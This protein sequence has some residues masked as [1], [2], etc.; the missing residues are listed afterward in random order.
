VV[1]LFRCGVVYECSDV[2][3]ERTASLFTLKMDAICLSETSEL[4]EIEAKRR[5]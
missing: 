3:G 5:P 1:F 4:C 2:S